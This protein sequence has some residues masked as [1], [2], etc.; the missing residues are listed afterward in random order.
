MDKKIRYITRVF[1]LDRIEQGLQASN[2]DKDDLEPILEDMEKHYGLKIISENK[3]VFLVMEYSN[4]IWNYKIYFGSYK[5]RFKPLAKDDER[6][7]KI[8]KGLLEDLKTMGINHLKDEVLTHLKD[9][10]YFEYQNKVEEQFK[11][12][13]V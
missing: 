6:W 8:E 5:K 13:C 7:Q 10:T 9:K 3:E 11:Q 4:I 12:Y 1:T 2:W